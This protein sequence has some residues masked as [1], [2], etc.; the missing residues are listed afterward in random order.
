M[1]SKMPFGLMNAGAIFQRDMAI[2]F[3]GEKEKFI[4]MTL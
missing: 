2:A 3:I 1:Y 4:W